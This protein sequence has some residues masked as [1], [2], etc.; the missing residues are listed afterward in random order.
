M[1]SGARH[2][3]SLSPDDNVQIKSP[4]VGA[5]VLPSL[6]K[7]LAL[8]TLSQL[9][10]VTAA[11]AQASVIA[12]LPSHA[13]VVPLP[14]FPTA[15]WIEFCEKDPRECIVDTSEP[16]EITLAV[17]VWEQIIS[18]NAFVNRIITPMADQDHW[19]VEDRWDYPLDGFGDCE[20]IQLLKRRL[21]IMAGLPRR[22]LRMTVVLD[23]VGAGHAVLMVRTDRGDFILDNKV[24]EVRLWHET[25]YEFLKREGA[26][27]M[28]WVA[29]G[30]P[31]ITATSSKP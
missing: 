8:F 15:A 19:A 25:G 9:L 21:L 24:N 31:S 5:C 4:H 6:I 26:E 22:A 23:E 14:A 11:F 30:A 7:V 16:A 13:N 3:K 18:V 12:P 10:I 27:G 20:D 28:T 29:L 17:S 2:L 1:L